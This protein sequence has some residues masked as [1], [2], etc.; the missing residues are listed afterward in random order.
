MSLRAYS[1]SLKQ[2]RSQKIEKIYNLNSKFCLSYYDEEKK[3]TGIIEYDNAFD[4]FKEFISRNTIVDDK[5]ENH[6]LFRCELD[7]LGNADKFQYLVFSVY[8]GYYGYS[9]SVIDRKTKTEVHKKTRDQADV[10]RFLVAVVIPTDSGTQKAK[11]G[12]MFF[13]EIGVFGVKIITT[14]A[15]Q[16]FFSEK[17]SISINKQKNHPHI[18][19]KKLLQKR[20]IQ[21]IRNTRATY[22]ADASDRLYGIEYGREEQTLTPLKVTNELKRALRHVSQSQY[23]YFSFDGR[24]YDDVKMVVKIGN[25]SRT[26]NLH[27]LDDLSIEEALPQELL[28][29][30]G[31]IAFD[32]FLSYLLEVATEYLEHLLTSF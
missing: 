26:I 8:S 31:T 14:K 7:T 11:R 12:L 23:N 10:Q 25:R 15:M 16:S 1:F 32:E 19:L 21:K 13:Q 28:L 5:I 29:S 27:G 30:D 17:F 20:L 22:S 24:D 9:S 4:L 6:S 3:Q 2:W 18:Y